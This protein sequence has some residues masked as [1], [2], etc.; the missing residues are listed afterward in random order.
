MAVEID[1]GQSNKATSDNNSDYIQ[2]IRK[3][4]RDKL[5]TLVTSDQMDPVRGAERGHIVL[6]CEGK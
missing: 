2:T 3:N 1:K 4:H 6:E 5:L